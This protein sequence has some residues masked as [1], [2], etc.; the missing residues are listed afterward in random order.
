MSVRSSQWRA[1]RWTTLGIVLLALFYA[2][3]PYWTLY[4]LDQALETHDT[5]RLDAMIDW[6]RL[7]RNLRDD[8]VA[9]ATARLLPNDAEARNRFGTDLLTAWGA[10]LIDA[11]TR[12]LLTSDALATLYDERR[13]AGAP[14]LLHA[15]R[16]ALFRSPTRF[17]VDVETG[18][19][20]RMRFEMTLESGAW[21]VTR[22]VR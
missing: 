14:S 10:A 6:P 18:R 4:R 3:Y 13:R 1:L 5:L 12:G 20:D 9:A 7:R 2:V 16:L 22:L 17:D 21:R 19:D 15:I 11:A 8:M